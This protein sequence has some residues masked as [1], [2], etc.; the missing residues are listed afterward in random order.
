VDYVSGLARN[1]R[2]LQRMIEREMWEAIE[3][4]KSSG[5]QARASYGVS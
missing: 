3:E 1:Q 2:R 4:W 5:Q